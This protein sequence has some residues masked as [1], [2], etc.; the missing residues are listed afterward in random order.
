MHDAITN[1]VFMILSMTGYGDAQASYRDKKISVEIRAL[2]GK[3]T[4]IRTKVPTQYRDK[5]LAIR[6]QIVAATQRGKMDVTVTIESDAGDES[7]ALNGSL[8][9]KYHREISKLEAQLGY[10][11]ADLT[12]AILRLPNVVMTVDEEVDEQEW[13]VLQATVERA[14][15][16]L[17]A[18]R[19][20][21]GLALMAD[22]NERIAMILKYLGEISPFEDERTERMRGKLRKLIDDNLA[23]DQVDNSR[24]EQEVLYYLERLDINEEKVRLTQHCQYFT[25]TLETEEVT[26]GRKLNFIAQEIGREINTLGAK[27][28]HSEIQRC[29]VQ[30]KDE[31]EKLK[32]QI[33]NTL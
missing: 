31:L 26:V 30:M 10:S 29:V 12:S 13:Q 4:D 23:P 14:L 32:E 1:A 7:F 6:N 17:N 11:S 25:E 3:I 18:F 9:T 16:Q 24:F 15:E 21:E 22:M 8:F 5:E 33:A 27:A 19:A 2:N 28:Q 20:Q